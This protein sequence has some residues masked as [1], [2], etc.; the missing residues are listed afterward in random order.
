MEGCDSGSADG[1]NFL[2]NIV[3]KKK[4]GQEVEE[5]N[6]RSS[7]VLDSAMPEVRTILKSSTVQ[8]T[9]I[10]FCLK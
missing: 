6:K 2:Q 9:S 1:H 10:I 8:I 7:T 4:K 3:K 5:K